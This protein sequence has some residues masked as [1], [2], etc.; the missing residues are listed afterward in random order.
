MDPGGFKQNLMGVHLHLTGELPRSCH[1][2]ENEGRAWVTK[3]LGVKFCHIF[4]ANF[5][6]KEMKAPVS[7]GIAT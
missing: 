5:R 4:G 7:I 6:L 2:E 3:I 1:Q